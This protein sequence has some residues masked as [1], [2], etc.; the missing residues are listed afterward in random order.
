LKKIINTGENLTIIKNLC[1]INNI[2][3]NSHQFQHN[4]HNI[5]HNNSFNKEIWI[6]I[7]LSIKMLFLMILEVKLMIQEEIFKILDKTP[8]NKFSKWLS[9]SR[10]LNKFNNNNTSKTNKLDSPHNNKISH[11]NKTNG[12]NIHQI[13]TSLIKIHHKIHS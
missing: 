4:S 12:L 10:S 3:I 2:L 8:D 5:N 13:K 11:H 6:K 7:W 1:K 9:N